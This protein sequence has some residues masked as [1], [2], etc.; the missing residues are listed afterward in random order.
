RRD[1]ERRRPRLRPLVARQGRRSGGRRRHS[2]RHLRLRASS[3]RL[4]HRVSESAARGPHRTPQAPSPG[5][6][7]V[8]ELHDVT[9]RYEAARAA[10][11]G[12]TLSIPTGECFGLIGSN[13]AGKTTTIRILATL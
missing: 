11:D 12:I 1:E 13:G 2:A 4:V 10:V 7:C 9:Y 6:V 8:I 5:R 3:R